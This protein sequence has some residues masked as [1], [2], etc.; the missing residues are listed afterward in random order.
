HLR[1]R[2]K[3]TRTEAR[4]LPEPIQSSSLRVCIQEPEPLTCSA[5][6]PPAAPPASSPAPTSSS[7]PAVKNLVAAHAASPPAPSCNAEKA[8]LATAATHAA[9]SLIKVL[10]AA[11]TEVG[12]PLTVAGFVV[13]AA[14][15]GA[16]TATLL[17]C[18]EAHAAK[19]PP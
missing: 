13:D 14:A 1:C 3:L 10:A 18:Q 4:Y 9:V 7:S 8:A 6:P 12:I 5:P 17:N 16:A 19:P 15:L 2:S 11:P